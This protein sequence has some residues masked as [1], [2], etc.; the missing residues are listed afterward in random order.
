MVFFIENL[1]GLEILAS[2]SEFSSRK[3][4]AF[5]NG[6]ISNY[7]SED[8]R[9][10]GFFIILGSRFMRIYRLL[11]SLL[12]FPVVL[13]DPTSLSY[14]CNLWGNVISDG[15]LTEFLFYFLRVPIKRFRSIEII[16]VEGEII[17]VHAIIGTNWFEFGSMTESS[18]LKHLLF[19]KK[20]FP[21]AIYY[22]H[23]REKSPYPEEIF[24]EY[25]KRPNMPLESW[26][27]KTG[28]PRRITS[29]C[30]TSLLLVAASNVGRT[31]VDL[32]CI[33]ESCFD[34]P[35]GSILENFKRPINGLD[36]LTVGDTQKFLLSRFRRLGITCNLV[37]QTC[38]D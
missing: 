35:R 38:Y 36:S 15:L 28:I 23:P 7:I 11:F 27:R 12:Q 3:F 34:G 9:C 6:N 8:L 18:Y 19:L 2:S 33:E 20:K 10:R 31:S 22:P 1:T 32:V 26:F 21:D 17:D 16:K 4:I 37:A 30:S 25:F 5:V 24:G 29:V 14:R 13:Q